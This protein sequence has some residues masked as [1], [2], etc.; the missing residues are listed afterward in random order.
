MVEDGVVHV[1]SGLISRYLVALDASSG[2]LLWR[3][4]IGSKR[5]SPEV[6]DG[7][8]YIS[9]DSG[10]NEKHL[11]A[12]DSDTGNLLWKFHTPFPLLNRY[13]YSPTVEKGVVYF[14]SED[15][16]L[17]ALEAASGEVLWRV[18]AGGLGELESSPPIV[19][20]GVIYINTKRSLFAS[21]RSRDWRKTVAF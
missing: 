21:F 15:S 12:L 4:R 14:A 20:D 3:Y 16:H 11:A 13:V 7:M 5:Y 9:S 17:Y 8:V 6:A 19:K 2:E 1:I 10:I 18:P